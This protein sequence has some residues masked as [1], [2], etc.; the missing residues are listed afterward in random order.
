MRWVK[1]EGSLHQTVE[2]LVFALHELVDYI[3]V[4]LFLVNAPMLD[5]IFRSLEDTFVQ[6]NFKR[7]LFWM[8][9][10]VATVIALFVFEHYTGLG[11][12]IRLD[13]ELSTLERLRTLE[14]EG[15]TSSPTLKKEYERIVAS[16]HNDGTSTMTF[17]NL[18]IEKGSVVKFFAATFLWWV[19]LI[20][21]FVTLARGD[22]QALPLIFG[23]I[24][25]L[26]LLGIPSII[27][28]DIG[29]FWINSIIY[30]LTQMF[31]TAWIH[32]YGKKRKT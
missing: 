16:L 17:L 27:I 10:I 15:I 5:T 9:L 20:Y 31:F 23:S 30:L 29:S 19:L 13:G 3:Q 14:K 1:P 8:F 21:G 6:F 4:C 2:S 32:N 24:T 26:L 22:D 28:P 12:N 25:V 11:H 7:L 18:D